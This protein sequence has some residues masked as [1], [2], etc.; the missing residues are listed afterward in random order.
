M[1]SLVGNVGKCFHVTFRVPEDGHIM[2][3]VIIDKNTLP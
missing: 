2:L 3:R 1:V